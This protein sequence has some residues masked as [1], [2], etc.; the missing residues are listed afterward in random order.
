MIITLK[1][2]DAVIEEEMK[3]RQRL[4]DN[5]LIAKYCF[6]DI[7]GSSQNMQYSIAI[8]KK[9][10]TVNSNVLIIGETGTG[11]EL[12]AHS[13]HKESSRCKQPFVALNC[14]ALP[15]NLLES[16]LF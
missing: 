13:I 8:A 6:D 5:G 2:T 10:S 14:A 9:Y 11:K 16:E 3:I 4:N 1:N 12:F 15:E 7:I